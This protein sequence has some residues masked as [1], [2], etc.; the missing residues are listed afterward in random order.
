MLQVH[1][2]LRSQRSIRDGNGYIDLPKFNIQNDCIPNCAIQQNV[3]SSD[4]TGLFNDSR[5]PYT[6][7]NGK[8]GERGLLHLLPLSNDD[9]SLSLS[10][11][12]YRV[13]L[14]QPKSNHGII[15]RPTPKLAKLRLP[16][17]ELAADSRPRLL[18]S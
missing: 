8:D 15:N 13:L 6:L 17:L 7:R 11:R 10:P 9:L 14:T 2:D 5:K 18:A 12:A 1:K 3:Q 4:Q 16:L